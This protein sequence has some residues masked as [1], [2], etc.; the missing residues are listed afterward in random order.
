MGPRTRFSRR[1][2]A[3]ERPGGIPL[4]L[5]DDQTKTISHARLSGRVLLR[6]DIPNNSQEQ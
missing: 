2:T 1:I 3:F 5:V 6:N 4:I